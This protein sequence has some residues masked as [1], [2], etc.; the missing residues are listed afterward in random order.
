MTTVTD[1][2]AAR[3]ELLRAESTAEWGL[4]A[5]GLLFGVSLAVKGNWRT[6]LRIGVAAGLV[7]A[8]WGLWGFFK[9]YNERSQPYP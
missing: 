3:R 1:I 5:A 9:L 8:A 2:V 6:W 4:L 7:A